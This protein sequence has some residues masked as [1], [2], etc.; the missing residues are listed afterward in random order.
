MTV[1]VIS[2]APPFSD[3]ELNGALTD[4]RKKLGPNGHLIV[5]L[6]ACHSGTGTRGSGMAGSVTAVDSN[7]YK[8]TLP[9]ILPIG[10]RTHFM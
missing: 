1:R 4:V 7:G 6:D 2:S 5:L 8:I 10:K 9:T 3:D